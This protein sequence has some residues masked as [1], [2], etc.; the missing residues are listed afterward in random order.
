MELNNYCLPDN[1]FHASGF[2]GQDHGVLKVDTVIQVF[3]LLGHNHL[4]NMNREDFS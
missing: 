4:Y 3:A 2:H 1:V